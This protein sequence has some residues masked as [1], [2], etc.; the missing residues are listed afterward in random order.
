[1]ITYAQTISPSE[2]TNA[3]RI[4]AVL[5]D[6]IVRLVL[7]PGDPVS[8]S[9]M[10]VRFGVSRQPVREALIRLAEAGLVSVQAR[11]A[12]RVVRISEKSVLNA[13]FIREA[14]E[15]E[16]MRRAAGLAQPHWRDVL[17]PLLEQ[18]AVAVL[19][20]D[21]RT[22]HAL[23]DA[24]HRKI[25]ELCEVEFV[26]DLIDAQKAQLDRVRYMTLDAAID[27]NLIEH[28]EIAQAI[29]DRDAGAAE[30]ALRNHVG[31]ITSHLALGRQRLPDYFAPK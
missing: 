13:K 22:F 27:I 4:V 16:I 26:W 21:L 14:L 7:K 11:K 30:T 3:E 8:E 28:R 15:V 9:E 5:R 6:E 17:E 12:T 18:Q 25:A 1:M 31:K 2:E 24:F 29:Y 10:A 19:A 23:D 20:K